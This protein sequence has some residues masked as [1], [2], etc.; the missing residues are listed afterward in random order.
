MGSLL[1]DMATIDARDSF[2]SP[3][4]C[5]RSVKSAASNRQRIAAHVR[6][7]ECRLAFCIDAAFGHPTRGLSPV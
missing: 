4:D 7:E 1:S 2:A 3:I 6:V 5:C